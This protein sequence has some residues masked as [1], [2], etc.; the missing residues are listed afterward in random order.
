MIE[1]RRLLKLDPAAWTALLAQESELRG[2]R[3]TAVTAQGVGGRAHLARYTLTLAGYSDPI[4]LIG[5][6][7]NPT[8][9]QVYRYLAPRL[10]F[11]T[12]RCWYSYLEAERGWLVLDDVPNDHPAERWVCADVDAVISDL[13]SLHA[14]FWEQDSHLSHHPW[15]PKQLSCFSESRNLY[16]ESP[17]FTPAGGRYLDS[18][19]TSA[20]SGLESLRA[21]GGWPGVLRHSHLEAAA[22]LL[23][24]PLPMLRPLQE[25]PQTLL[26]GDLAAHH[27]HLTLFGDR[28]LLDWQEAAVGPA[29]CDLIGF[30]EQFELLG[31]S[32]DGWRLRGEWPATVETIIDSYVLRMAAE[33]GPRFNARA[34][35]RA[36]PAARCLYVLLHWL[37]RLGQWLEQIPDAPP[38]RQKLRYLNDDELMAAGHTDVVELRPYLAGVFHRFLNAYRRL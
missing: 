4:T 14:T 13:T 11:L 32:P 12:A 29:V 18:A 31:K 26:H 2:E 24:D 7:T 37:P 6:W 21:L 34:L 38:T 22:D 35:R 9:V 5:K 15:L 33:L 1:L 23:D 10:S 3:V 27:W 25:L 17:S 19:L 20:A 28:R 30:V 8:E 16:D 36:I